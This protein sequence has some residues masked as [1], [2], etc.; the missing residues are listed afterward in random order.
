MLITV[1]AIG[2]YLLAK[3]PELKGKAPTSIA[4][5]VTLPTPFAITLTPQPNTFR[6]AVNQAM[7]AAKI[8]QL[9]KSPDEWKTVVSQWE[10][11]M[12]LMK[13]VPSSSPNY[14]VAQQKIREY[15]RNLN[16]AKKNAV[17]GK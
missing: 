14:V 12:A 15:Q 17:G 8:T 11:A 10:A 3:I 2:I 9:A 4:S 6:E 16:Y 5:R 13:A 7:S 1:V